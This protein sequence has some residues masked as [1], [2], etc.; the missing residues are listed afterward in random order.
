MTDAAFLDLYKS[1]KNKE[2]NMLKQ[3]QLYLLK[4]HFLSKNPNSLSEKLSGEDGFKE[5]V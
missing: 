4:L 5:L 1:R 3:T 2:V